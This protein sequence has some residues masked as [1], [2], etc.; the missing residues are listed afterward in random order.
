VRHR[1][2]PEG[3]P[4]NSQGKLLLTTLDNELVLPSVLYE[5]TAKYHVPDV[6]PVTVPVV[7]VA[8]VIC[9]DFDKALALVP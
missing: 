1:G 7:A 6:S 9:S 3:G 2:R 4:I 8:L 5:T